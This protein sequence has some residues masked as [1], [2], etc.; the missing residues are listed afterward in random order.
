ATGRPAATRTVPACRPRRA[1]AGGAGPAAT[2]AARSAGPHAGPTPARGTT[3]HARLPRLPGAA[4]FPGTGRHRPGNLRPAGAPSR[5]WLTGAWPTSPRLTRAGLA[6]A[7]S[8]A[9][10]TGASVPGGAGLAW[11]FSA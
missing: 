11:P 3:R 9:G 5:T 10:L 7:R 2:A 6:G 1:P 8:G 4:A